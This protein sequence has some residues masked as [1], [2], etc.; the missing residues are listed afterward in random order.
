[1]KDLITDIVQALVD[2]PEEVSVNEVGGSHTTVLEVRVAKT[3][4]G[5]VIG[6][7]GRTAQAIR[8]VLNA[9]AGKTRQRYVLEIIE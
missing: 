6:K 4:I 3:D 9:A 2:H 5:K 7:Q 8:T 1:M